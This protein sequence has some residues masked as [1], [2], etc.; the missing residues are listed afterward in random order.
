MSEMLKNILQQS[1]LSLVGY[2][3]C[4]PE[5]ALKVKNKNIQPN[6]FLN[7]DC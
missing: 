2:S 1:E 6:Q 4:R 7:F 5:G 3:G